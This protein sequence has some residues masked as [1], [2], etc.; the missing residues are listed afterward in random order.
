MQIV[1]YV[2]FP[3]VSVGAWSPFKEQ[4]KVC[5]RHARPG[6]PVGLR[7]R[8]VDDEEPKPLILFEAGEEGE[9]RFAQWCDT[10]RAW[11][12]EGVIANLALVAHEGVKAAAEAIE[13]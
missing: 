2:N 10:H 5:I 8:F 12:A 1:P 4:G 7:I 6:V 13:E 9:K 3:K 11:F